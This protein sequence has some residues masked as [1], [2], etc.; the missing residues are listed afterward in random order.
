MSIFFPDRHLQLMSSQ[1]TVAR[2]TVTQTRRTRKL[3]VLLATFAR[4]PLEYPHQS[5]SFSL[6]L[7]RLPFYL[8][9]QATGLLPRICVLTS[10][11][12]WLRTALTRHSSAL[13][14]MGMDSRTSSAHRPQRLMRRV[15]LLYSCRPSP[16]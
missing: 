4:L 15:W 2:S 8:T 10:Q 12:S 16:P 7:E 14:S 3:W 11:R 9:W 1:R 5:W 6:H 13:T